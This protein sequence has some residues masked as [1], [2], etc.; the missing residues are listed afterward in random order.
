MCLNQISDRERVGILRTGIR[1]FVW[2]SLKIINPPISLNLLTI[3]SKLLLLSRGL[4]PPLLREYAM[5]SHQGGT[6]KDNAYHQGLLPTLFY[7]L[8]TITWVSSQ[9][10]WSRQVRDC[11]RKWQLTTKRIVE[12]TYTHTNK[13]PRTVHQDTEGAN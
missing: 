10:S 13:N 3:G 7:C 4:E 1:T 6:S 8:Q 2:M 11:S 12:P 9:Y 5:I